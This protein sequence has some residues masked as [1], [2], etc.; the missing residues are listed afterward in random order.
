MSTS[1][2]GLVLEA[3][4]SFGV[5]GVNTTPLVIALGQAARKPG[6]PDVERTLAELEKAGR[7]FKVIGLEN[8]WFLTPTEWVNRLLLGPVCEAFKP[9][10]ANLQA[11]ATFATSAADLLAG[12]K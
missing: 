11:G 9:D 7:V 2:L 1:R 10:P 3:V 4:A 6:R 5:Y 8:R 12:R